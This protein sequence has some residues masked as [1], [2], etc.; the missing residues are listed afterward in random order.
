[1]AWIRKIDGRQTAL[2]I[3][4][5]VFLVFSL[6][7]GDLFLSQGNIENVARQISLDAPI[8]FGETIVLIAGGIDISVGS[9]MAMASALAIVPQRT[10]SR[11]AP[12]FCGSSQ[13]LLV[14]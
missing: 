6:A 5:S 1:M 13:L 2:F 4:V 8:V 12:S 10:A 7:A 3:A 9:N 11:K 14:T